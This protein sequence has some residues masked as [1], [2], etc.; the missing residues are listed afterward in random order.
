LDAAS[1]GRCEVPSSD[2]VTGG[3]TVEN[4]GDELAAG[5]KFV[6]GDGSVVGV[7]GRGTVVIIGG[8]RG[9]WGTGNG[10]LATRSD[11]GGARRTAAATEY[12]NNKNK[13]KNKNENE[14]EIEGLF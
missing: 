14:N 2:E 9:W 11:V 8:R 13:N 4:R 1:R 5:R 12:I 6:A 7:V 3:T 10:V